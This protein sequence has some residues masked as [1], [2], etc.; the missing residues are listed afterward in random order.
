MWK[1]SVFSLNNLLQISGQRFCEAAF[2]GAYANSNRMQPKF[3]S[4]S[5]TNALFQS[6]CPAPLDQFYCRNGGECYARYEEIEHDNI[7]LQLSGAATEGESTLLCNIIIYIYD[8]S[9]RYLSKLT[10]RRSRRWSIRVFSKRKLLIWL[11]LSRAE[12]TTCSVLQMRTQLSRQAMRAHLWSWLVRISSKF[13]LFTLLFLLTNHG[14]I[15]LVW[16]PRQRGLCSRRFLWRS[17]STF[18]SSVS[19]PSSTFWCR[20]YWFSG[21][22][23]VLFVAYARAHFVGRT[24]YPSVLCS[25]LSS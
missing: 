18:H 2:S 13:L 23:C 11:C 6:P 21:G 19:S 22:L 1:K 12:T 8:F 14:S 25:L 7:G 16:Q 4:V 24:S 17:K 9:E 15:N 10:Q 5:T 3:G 20:R